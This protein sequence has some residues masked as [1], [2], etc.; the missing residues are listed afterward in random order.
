MQ[1]LS[2]LLTGYFSFKAFFYIKEYKKHTSPKMKGLCIISVLAHLGVAAVW[3]YL[4][5]SE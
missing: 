2:I 5:L 1:L 3:F 4:G